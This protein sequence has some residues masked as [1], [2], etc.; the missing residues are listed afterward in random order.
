MLW[1]SSYTAVLALAIASTNAQESPLN[2]AT[3]P[4]HY[5]SPWMRGAEGWE[6]AYEKAKAF[7]SGL[8]L[9]EKVNLTTGVGWSGEQCVGNTGS[10]PRLD[11]RG[12]C[13]QDG[14]LGIRFTDFATLWPSGMNAGATWSRRLI[15]ERGFAMAEEHKKKGV[16][17]QLSPVA[18][19]LGRTPLGGRNWE[20]F[21]SD[22]VLT[23]IA[24]AETIKGIQDAGVI[25][26]AKH[27]I[28]NEQEHNRDL[29]DNGNTPAYSANIDD[30]TMHELYLWPFA[31]AVRAGVGAIMSSYNQINNSYA[32]QNSYLVNYILKNELD[33]QGFVM[34]DW[35]S[36]HTGVAA[37][38]AGTDMS[39]AG[40]KL[41]ASG[42]TWWGGSLTEAVLNGT[43]PQWRLDDMA[44]RIM[45][46]YFKVGAEKA[47]VPINFSSWTNETFGWRHDQADEYWEQVNWHVDV[48]GDHK[49]LA[50]EVAGASTV[51][52]KNNGV[53]PL[54]G[55]KSVAVIG[56]DAHDNPAGPNSFADRGGNSGTLAQGWGSG[57]ANYPYLIAPVTALR[58]Q[59]A[60]SKSA[61][62]NVS[63]NYNFDAVTQAVAGAEVAIVFANANSGEGYITVDGNTG[64]RN[65]LT[66]WGNGDALIAHVA[67]QNPNTVVVLHTVG[68]VIVEDMKNNPNIT[69][70]IWAGL[71]G[72]ESG[73]AITDILYGVRNPS[74][75]T[76]F[77]WGKKREDWG[78]DVIYTPT[79][80]PSQ[81]NFDE[82]VMHDH[83]HFDQL[84]IEP[85][86]EFGFGLSYT[87][88]TYSNL[89]VVKNTPE[90]YL[91]TSGMT[92]AAETFGT[93]NFNDTSAHQFPPGFKIIKGYVYPFLSGPVSRNQTQ[94]WPEK[95]SD[96]SPQPKVGAGGSPGGNKQLW[97]VMYTV[98]ATV[99]NDGDVKG[100]EVSQLYLSLGGPADP[101][102]V[103]RGFDDLELEPQEEKTFTVEITRRDISNW[104]TTTQNWVISEF[105]K[106][107]HVG[108]SSRCLPLSAPLA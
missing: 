99:K 38:L 16:D 102:L 77:T 43:V 100:T 83:R 60:E 11:F 92:K 23:G 74:A 70:I 51:L 107:V 56:E 90:P 62:T 5:P 14:P 59:A 72:Q 84:D 80:V 44:T 15:K 97:D 71:P 17:I 19:P 50:R 12:L 55:P 76:V 2:W 13:L 29:T 9:T 27:F 21:A 67:S 45:S 53:L 81:M 42:D 93:I 47:R 87:N 89:Q 79:T 86:Y 101:K 24:M 37:A 35:W 63:D 18:G 61:F 1:S 91:L 104:D 94:N 52:L 64:D 65:N 10:I 3:S 6:E 22:P 49:V 32:A 31:D 25:A 26:T 68:P 7:V 57:S 39:M 20:G 105:E 106:T 54:S 30:K 98:T 66:L 96:P 69:A 46:A 33:F 75:K 58:A 73:N 8:T 82:G 103:L 41:F 48:Q 40:D 85:S 4:P 108:R 34:S 36:Q 95:S 88:F 78:V 28:G